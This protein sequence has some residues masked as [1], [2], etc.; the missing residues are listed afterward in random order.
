MLVQ[1]NSISEL[2]RLAK[3]QRDE[4]I[5]MIKKT[6]GITIRQLARVAGISKSVSDRN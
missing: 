3:E 1:I 5:R 2:Q 4:V 6:K